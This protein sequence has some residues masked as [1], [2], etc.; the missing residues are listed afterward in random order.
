MDTRVVLE[1]AIQKYRIDYIKRLINASEDHWS[2]ISSIIV[3]SSCDE[4]NANLSLTYEHHTDL[5]NLNDYCF[6]DESESEDSLS[7]SR[8][9][10]LECGYSNGKFFITGKT[11][12]RV[13]S[14]RNAGK[15]P[16]VY[17]TTYEHEID[18]INQNILLQEYADNKNVPEWLI[19]SLF[20]VL[21]TSDIDIEVLIADLSF[22]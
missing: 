9:T 2:T 20:N 22:A 16:I 18:E 19:I 5:Y 12:I 10:V 17:S 11:P 7:I 15:R 3:S 8:N 6:N 21:K 4:K 1:K 14:K 13:Y